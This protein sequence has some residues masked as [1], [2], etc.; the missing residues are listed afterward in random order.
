MIFRPLCG[1]SRSCRI[2]RCTGEKISQEAS[3]NVLKQRRVQNRNRAPSGETCTIHRDEGK[4][5]IR[6]ALAFPNTYYVGMSN[7]GFQTVYR[8]FNSR[9]G[10]VC[11]RFFLPDADTSQT[12][13]TQKTEFLSLESGRPLG[14]FHIIAFSLSF[15]ND[16]L[17]ILT[18]LDMGGVQRLSN[19]RTR[20]SPLVIAGGVAVFLNPEPLAE[21]F[22]LFLIGEAEEMIGEFLDVVMES[23]KRGRWRKP[24][25]S[26]FAG[27]SGVYVPSAYSVTYRSDGC[28]E[29]FSPA[30]GFPDHVLCMHVKSLDAY[31][32]SSC[33]RT[34][35]TELG[36]MTLLEVSRG[37]TRRCRFCAVGTVYRPFRIRSIHSL[38]EELE[39]SCAEDMR[40][41][42]LGAAVSDH[43]ELVT[44]LRHIASVKGTA[45]VSSLRADALTEEMIELL[46]QCG[47]KTFTIA[48]EAGS[49]RLR[50]A[51]A[52]QLSDDEIFNAV[53]TLARAR[54]QNIKLY[55]MI[56][57]PT[58][59][60]QDIQAIVRLVKA[61][62][63][64]YVHEAKSEK[65]LSHIQ[66]TISMF[67]PKPATPFQ[68]HPFED[69]ARLK[70]K[71]KAI[72][73]PLRH[74]RKITVSYD[75]PK[76]AYVQA[77]LSRGDRRAVRL[78][79]K[80][81]EHGG[82]WN[83]AFRESDI[84]PDFYVY[85]QRPFEEQLPWDFIK[86]T[87]SKETLWK[88]YLDAIRA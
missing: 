63:H 9:P 4:A 35:L 83:R 66:L 29:S 52:K 78:L 70:Q 27:V 8:L 46:V 34:P 60:D 55:F 80:A 5:I 58:E 79:I 59:T 69:V 1:V 37:C 67:V 41:G 23:C 56:G 87:V 71:L 49:E 20:E 36:T 38:L 40:I 74:E 32:A 17:N 14:F 82:D 22:D 33:F 81:Y 30:A 42:V 2:C 84:N 47:H 57:L 76:W 88:E 85:R 43:P 86:H 73:G 6:I 26:A 62:K 61:I 18:M 12:S 75:L 44:L 50:E 53:K 77:L 45:S 64:T 54:V 15:E 68:W 28:V 10:I 31:P 16:Y 19:M 48:P 24:E 13:N 3:E 25:L 65:W 11:E 51:I 39:K 21:I 72:T 7:L